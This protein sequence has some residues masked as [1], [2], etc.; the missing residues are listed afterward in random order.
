MPGNSSCPLWPLLALCDQFKSSKY[1]MERVQPA[2]F[3]WWLLAL[4]T[5]VLESVCVNVLLC[6]GGFSGSE[7]L[8]CGRDLELVLQHPPSRFLLCVGPLC[9]KFGLEGSLLFID[10][11][12]ACTALSSVW[13][14]GGGL[15]ANPRP[16]ESLLCCWPRFSSLPFCFS[17]FWHFK[18]L[19]A[20]LQCFLRFILERLTL[21]K[22]NWSSCKLNLEVTSQNY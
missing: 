16:P 10:S 4:M 19:V 17:V 7:A 1:R 21:P 11:V 20:M 22:H 18:W 6:V 15:H 9:C 14:R 13:A 12:P 5:H 8:P 2:C 3:K